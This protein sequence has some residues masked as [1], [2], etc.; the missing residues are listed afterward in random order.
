H[1]LNRLKQSPSPGM[2]ALCESAGLQPGADLRA[3][4]V[5]YKLAPR[6]NAAGRLGSAR[7]V[8]E[9]LTTLQPEVAVDLARSLE[10]EDQRRQ[11]MERQMV[12]Q[13]R[14]LVEEADLA[15]DPALV[16]AHSDWHPGIIGI[17]AGR[18]ADLYGRPALM[19]ALPSPIR[20]NRERERELPDLALGSGR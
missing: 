14:H 3:S 20:P 6:L 9:L 4:D 5:G 10:E 13:A 19:I 8:V 18:M 17:V 7:R 16:L 11:E 1:G 12:A 2:R 15:R